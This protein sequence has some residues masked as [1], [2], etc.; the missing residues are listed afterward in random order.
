[1]HIINRLKH[2]SWVGI[3]LPLA[4]AI[5]STF[6]PA[7][8]RAT[9][10][11]L[12]VMAATWTFHYTELGGK[13]LKRT[14]PVGLALAVLALL[15]FL[16]G[17]R[18]DQSARGIPTAENQQQTRTPDPPL[19]TPPEVKPEEKKPDKKDQDAKKLKPEPNVDK[20]K[21]DIKTGNIDQGACSN[22]Q[23]GS[24]GNQ[25]VNC[26]PPSRRIPSEIRP[27]L[28][29]ILS[30]SPGDITVESL[31]SDSEGLR[32]ALDWREVL[33]AAGWRIQQI[34]IDYLSVYGVF[35]VMDG[36]HRQ[37]SVAETDIPSGTPVAG[38]LEALHK[39]NVDG[40]SVSMSP[41]VLNLP[42]GTMK[43]IIGY[44]PGSNQ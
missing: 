23:I 3:V 5:G 29:E 1:M 36:D 37:D 39:L 11:V 44:R 19:P 42:K 31:V 30:K 35:V 41:K 24:S 40:L 27:S 14:A 20:P 2:P 17:R 22:L 7:G 12:A 9:L 10:L 8:L 34:G 6:S 15:I 26:G 4:L 16:M 13:K 33:G 32:F 25:T 38:L 28:I 21:Q 43:L 18:F